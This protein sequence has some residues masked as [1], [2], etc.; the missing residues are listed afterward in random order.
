VKPST[1]VLRSFL[2]LLAA[3]ISTAAQAGGVHA[4]AEAIDNRYNH[5]RSLQ[6]DFAEIYR[7]VGIEREE[8][9]TVWLKK[10]GKMRWEYRSPTQKL[11]LCNGT[12]AWLYVPGES[13]AR[14]TAQRRLDDLRS[15]L[16]F[17]IGKTRLERELQGLS[18]APDVPP[19]TSGNQV[20]RGI[21]KAL[22]G[23]VSQVL[24]EVSPDHWIVRIVLEGED[25][26]TTEYRFSN[27]RANLEIAN[28]FFELKVPAGVEIVD[29]GFEP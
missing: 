1:L 26:S 2:V 13:Q 16:A 20:L 7:G 18:F 22:A 17:L 15:P 29:D 14:R 9:G 10:T 3:A 19:L 27:P 4:T 6:A 25:G 5:L 8:S 12:E 23:Q 28:Q 21:P 24:L 11:F